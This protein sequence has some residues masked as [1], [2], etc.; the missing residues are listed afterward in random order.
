[1]CSQH[2][3]TLEMEREALSRLFDL[4]DAVDVTTVMVELN[5]WLQ[6]DSAHRLAWSRARQIARLTAAYLRATD[7]GA[8]KEQMDRFVDAIDDERRLRE[9]LKDPVYACDCPR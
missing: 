7:P 1:M 5:T 2:D 8:G 4:I 3:V 9:A 6:Q